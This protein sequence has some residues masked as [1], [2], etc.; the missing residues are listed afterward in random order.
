MGV[1]TRRGSFYLYTARRIG[2]RVVKKYVGPVSERKARSLRQQA[3]LTS[4]S[5]K[6][7]RIERARTT[8]EGVAVLSALDPFDKVADRVFRAVMHL[9]G[10]HRHHRGEWRRKRGETPMNFIQY[11]TKTY[12]PK[13]PAP[14]LVR[15]TASK[16]EDQ[17]VLDAAA[18][19]DPSALPA[20]RELLKDRG[21]L[22]SLGS[23]AWMARQK[24]VRQAAGDDVAIAEGVRRMYA[25]H[26]E[27]LTAEDG[28]DPPF[29]IHLAAV[30]VAHCWL[31]VHILE[32]KSARLKAG[33]VS[34]VAVERQL[35]SAERRLATAL[36]SLAVL[37]RLNQPRVVAQVNVLTGSMVVANR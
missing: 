4:K 36:K 16:P 30:R 6:A 21:W 35:A 20:V 10:Y 19:G 34:A 31:A 1:E 5:R 27:K 29:P 22:T 37:R 12:G 33:S 7:R 8:A 11:L 25:E 17:K 3:A 2:R 13:R 14:A 9:S 18:E 28:P 32:A 15:L 24:L 26:Y 23:V